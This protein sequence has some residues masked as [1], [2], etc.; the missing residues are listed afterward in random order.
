[1]F[2]NVKQLA[3]DAAIIAR[4][5]LDVEW[6]LAKL[7]FERSGRIAGK[8]RVLIIACD[9]D[10]PQGSMGDM[11]MLSGVMQGY[12]DRD[13]NTD[14][15]IIGTRDHSISV[16]LIG[17][18]PVIA[19][20]RGRAG[21]VAFQQALKDHDAILGLG[22]DVLDGKYGA[23]LV[24]R[25]ASY[26]NYAAAHGVTAGIVGFSFNA[27]PRRPACYALSRLSSDVR[28][29]VRDQ[30]SLQ[31]FSAATSTYATLC[32][33]A[34][35]IMKP[36]TS[37]PSAVENSTA[38]WR[39]AG[40]TPVAVNLS[41]HALSTL[42][43]RHTE[44]EIVAIIARH[45]AQSAMVHR[46][47]Y[48]LLPHDTKPQSGDI[49]LLKALEYE[50]KTLGMSNVEYVMLNNPAE[51]KAAVKLVD[52]VITGRM[53]LAIASLGTGTPILSITYQD[54]FEGLYK[55]FGINEGY[56]ITPDACIGNDFPTCIDR[57]FSNLVAYRNGIA[58]HQE[59]VRALAERNILEID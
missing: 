28:I 33:D 57:L 10:A 25:F 27:T 34:A 30:F 59:K 31:R 23:A 14:F 39:I 16:P 12:R 36:S 32:A 3:T 44:A 43:P 18:V 5:F 51:V 47:A 52:F 6:P 22:A 58:N 26:L 13:A 46:L 48:L 8:K 42:I 1:M 20:W 50:L 38:Q 4:N 37:L 17:K 49:R 19:A 55:H 35:F 21:T 56:M 15:T 11:A 29:N 41:A 24:C 40:L 7:P 2:E 53:H 45:L 9:P 54:K